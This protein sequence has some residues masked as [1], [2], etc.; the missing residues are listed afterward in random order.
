MDVDV[1]CI[2]L[3][4]IYHYTINNYIYLY[5]INNRSLIVL[6]LDTRVWSRISKQTMK[7]M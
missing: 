7:C 5:I 4:Y 2:K 6:Q 3:Y 1:V